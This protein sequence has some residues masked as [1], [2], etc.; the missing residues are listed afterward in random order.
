MYS[1]LLQ[2]VMKVENVEDLCVKVDLKEGIVYPLCFISHESLKYLVVDSTGEDGC[3]RKVV[4]PKSEILSISVV[5]E[6]DIQGIFDSD[7]KE[8]KMFG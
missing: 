8:E 5:Y 1:K 7:N 6:Q 2:D 4:L 3:E